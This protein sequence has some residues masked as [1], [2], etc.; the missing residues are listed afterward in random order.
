MEEHKK[1]KD[2]H[3]PK[4]AEQP[5]KE[6]LGPGESVTIGVIEEQLRVDKE[7]V[8]TG[9]VYISKKVHEKEETID[10]PGSREEVDIQRVPINKYVETA[11]PAV[12]HEG[13]KMII[14]VLREVAVVEKRLVLVEELHVTKRQVKTED[15]QSV[16]LRKEEVNVD[17]KKSDKLD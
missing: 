11:P 17:R 5:S 2:I 6:K 16:T 7:V 10:L 1:N 14:P 13:D 8:E 12:R 3:Q 15:R 4:E 9:R